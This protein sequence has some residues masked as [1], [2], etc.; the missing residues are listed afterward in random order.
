MEMEYI[1]NTDLLLFISH[2]LSIV[3]L[4]LSVKGTLKPRKLFRL[5]IQC[6]K[7][8]GLLRV[9]LIYLSEPV[10]LFM[11]ATRPICLSNIISVTDIDRKLRN[12]VVRR[13]ELVM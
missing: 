11:Y 1:K 2:K 10:N 7:N 6:L 8:S 9:L 12:R 3:S 4:S 13:C 5:E